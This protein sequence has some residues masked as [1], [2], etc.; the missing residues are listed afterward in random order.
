VFAVLDTNHFSELDRAGDG[1]ERL[2]Q[3]ILD[4]RGD[5]FITVI[6]IEEVTQGWLARLR[7]CKTPGDQIAIYARLRKAVEVLSDWDVLPWDVEAV[8]IYERLQ[9]ARVRAGAL[10]L[11]IASIALASDATLLTRNRRDFAKIPRLRMENWL[12]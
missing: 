11:K 7:R 6:T 12:D 10:D 9:K 1:G 5:L 3:R 4:F 8:A 2:R